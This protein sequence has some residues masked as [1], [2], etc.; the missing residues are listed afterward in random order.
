[1]KVGALFYERLVICDLLWVSAPRVV[2]VCRHL[3]ISGM[4]HT[5]VTMLIHDIEINNKNW[6]PARTDL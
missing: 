4:F 5:C 2:H 3:F 1:M 6:K